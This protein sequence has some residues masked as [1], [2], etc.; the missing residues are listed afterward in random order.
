MFSLS[1]GICWN[2]NGKAGNL[3]DFFLG[4][5]TLISRDLMALFLDFIMFV[6]RNL[7]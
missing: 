2:L 5:T 7:S 6:K 1:R 3:R 4:L